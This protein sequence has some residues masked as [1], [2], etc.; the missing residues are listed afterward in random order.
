MQLGAKPITCS[1]SSGTVIDEAG[2]TPEDAILME[3]KNHY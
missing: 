3:I 2:F 1:D